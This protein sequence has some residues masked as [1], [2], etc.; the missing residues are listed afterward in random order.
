METYKTNYPFLYIV[1]QVTLAVNIGLRC[2][3][4]PIYFALKK[5]MEGDG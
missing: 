2:S 1:P 4:F 5:E 3:A